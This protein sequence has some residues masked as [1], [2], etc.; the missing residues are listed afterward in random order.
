MARCAT[1]VYPSR[2]T[3]CVADAGA[4]VPAAGVLFY[5]RH[6]ETRELQ[7]ALLHYV[8]KPNGPAKLDVFGGKCEP[9]DRGLPG[10]LAREFAEEMYHLQTVSYATFDRALKA[11]RRVFPPDADAPLDA[12][13]A[14]D[15]GASGGDGGATPDAGGAVASELVYLPHKADRTFSFACLITEY[16]A[17]LSLPRPKKYRAARA[18]AM[19]ST[20][21]PIDHF[22]EMSVHWVDYASIVERRGLQPERRLHCVLEQQ[23]LLTEL[24]AYIPRA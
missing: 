12:D 24:A 1:P 8:D 13:A 18:Q 2:R 23:K 6:P 16:P 19:Q 17:H 11:A 15:D 21:P 10:T 14:A 9:Y 22:G 3:W 4:R 5:R 7:L 20:V